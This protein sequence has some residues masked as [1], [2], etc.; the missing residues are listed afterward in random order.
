M[1]RFVMGLVAALVLLTG[2]GI[3]A[4]TGGSVGHALPHQV[5]GIIWGN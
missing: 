3:Y 2:V 1:R 4:Q 5:L